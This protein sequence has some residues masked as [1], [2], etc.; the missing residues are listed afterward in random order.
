MDEISVSV[1]MCTRDGVA[2]VEDQ[3]RSLLDQTRPP[4]EIVVS[5]DASRDGTAERVS[6]FAQ[7]SRVPVRVR[8][9]PSP[10]GYRENFERAI[11]ACTGDVIFLADQDDVWLP[12][13][14][15]E[16]LGPFASEG[17]GI[18]HCDAT[19]TDA[20][21]DPTG[22]TVFS[23]QPGLGL[24]RR[25]SPVE[26][27]RGVG[28]PG[29]TMAFRADLG[30]F[31]LPLSR[32]WGHDLWIVL[33]GSALAEVVPVTRPLMLYRRH[34]G[35]AGP[36]R[37]IDAGPTDRALEGIRGRGA[38]HYALDRQKWGELVGR[39]EDAGRALPDG[40]PRLDRLEA[41]LDEYRRRRDLA[42]FRD[43]IRNRPRWARLGPIAR[44]TPEY[45]RY[46]HAVASPAKDAFL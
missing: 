21:L 1:A 14:I 3:L 41:F 16:M 34:A 13:K 11:G 17:A 38:D 35:S 22:G 44:R 23:T 43:E 33:V 4:D 37:L 24:D 31:L 19:V 45:R 2:F 10:V 5:D 18:V 32:L 6:E 42:R 27:V 20:E 12:E 7:G 40:D 28:I 30:G 26:L 9:N 8:R 39:V 36:S 25:R 29:C 15:A 46:L